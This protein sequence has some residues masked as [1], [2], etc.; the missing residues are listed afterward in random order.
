MKKLYSKTG[1]QMLRLSV[2]F[3]LCLTGGCKKENAGSDVTVT[4]ERSGEVIL[5]PGQGWVLYSGPG[6]HSAATMALGTAGYDRFNWATL[7]PQ[8]D[9]YNWAAIDSRIDAWARHGKQFAFGVMSVNISSE[10]VYATPKWVFDKGAKYTMGKGYNTAPKYYVPV[11][12]DPVYV[13]EQKKFIEALAERY[14]GNPNIAFIDIRNFGNWGEIHMYPLYDEHWLPQH[15]ISAGEVQ[16]LLFRPYIDNFRQTPVIMSWSNPKGPLGDDINSWA[17][18]NGLGLRSD[19]IMGDYSD[20]DGKALARA[21]GKTPIAW[22]FRSRIADFEAQNIWDDNKFINAVKDNKPSYIGLGHWD[23]HEYFL[24]KKPDLIKKA[25]NMMGYHFVMTG[26]TYPRTLHVGQA[27]PLTLSIENTGVTTMITDCVIKLALLDENGK[28]VSLFT[29]DWDAHHIKSG[30]T[31]E[32]HTA[33]VFADAPAGDCQLAMGLFRSET[34][35]KPA[36]R[37]ENNGITA[38]GWYVIGDVAVEGGNDAKD[39]Q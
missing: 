27:A 14:D 8:E 22:E 24:S 26:A 17:V 5:N 33:V 39:E 18:A 16:N 4:F 1:V 32:L 12:N 3:I 29:T 31:T 19:G 9:V 6:A 21:A 10:N 20:P 7:H 23:D 36:Y 38:D 25:A 35:A 11:W 30:E 2:L 37:M 28:A 15:W 34:D 13:A